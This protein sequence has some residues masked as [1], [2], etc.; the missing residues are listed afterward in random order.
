[1]Q[2]RVLESFY[3]ILN[4]SDVKHYN[5]N[6][7]AVSQMMQDNTFYLSRPKWIINTRYLYA[8]FTLYSIW[9]SIHKPYS[10][11]ACTKQIFLICDS[12]AVHHSPIAKEV[13]ECLHI[14]L[15]QIPKGD[16]DELQPL[17]RRILRA[18][19]ARGRAKLNCYIDSMVLDAFDSWIALAL[20]NFTK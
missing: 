2:N 15:V 1:M 10:E 3:E 8:L 6:R 19:K 9:G 13:A 5:D 7:V 17:D 16:T 20:P 4:V 12:D 14:E 11:S 18:L